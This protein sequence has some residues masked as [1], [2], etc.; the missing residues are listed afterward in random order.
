[1]RH[2]APGVLAACAALLLFGGMV[3]A[4]PPDSGYSLLHSYAFGAAPGS[5]TE[6]FDYVTVDSAARRLYLSRGTAV[7]V[8][9]A[10]T[11][12]AI[13][14]VSGLKRQHGVA[15]APEFGRGFASDGTQAKIVIFDLKTLNIVGEAKADPDADCVVYDP[16]SK[17]VFSMNGDSHSSTVVD[18]KTGQVVKTIDLGGAPEFAVADGKGMVY[19]SLANQNQIA[20]IDSHTL[21]VKSRWPVAPAGNPT[22][23]AMD[24]EHRRLFSAGRNPQMLVILDADSGKI[25]QSFAIS[26]GTDAAAYDPETGMIFVSTRDG[27][28]HIFHED[29]PDKYSVVDT[30]KTQ[31]GAKTMGLDTKTHRLFLDTSEFGAAPA[32]TA[33]RPNPQPQAVL[34]TFRVLVYGSGGAPASASTGAAAAPAASSAAGATESEAALVARGKARFG[35]YRCFD[36]H[37]MNGE[38]TDDAPDLIGTHLNG[39]EIAKFLQKPSA[40]A[41]AKGMPDVPMTSADSKALVAYVL[42]LKRAK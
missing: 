39:N 26:A 40:D 34:G 17:R 19:A 31:F 10:D 1:M 36:C 8:I 2:F 28:I 16:A 33:D 5:T 32:A 14:Y 30:V 22:A 29:A 15:L 42:S 12:A 3:I 24:R 9:D 4:R 41:T 27:N 20:A 21:E 25:V 18:A 11:G 7:Q 13:G 35:A 37:G 6:Y 38:G 23:L